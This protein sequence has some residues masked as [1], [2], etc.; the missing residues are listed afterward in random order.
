MLKPDW[1]RDRPDHIQAGILTTLL[2]DRDDVATLTA[3]DQDLRSA[4]TF[5]QEPD[6][7]DTKDAG[8]TQIERNHSRLKGTHELLHRRPVDGDADLITAFF[9]DHF[10]QTADS[11]FIFGNE[12][13]IRGHEGSKG[14]NGAPAMRAPLRESWSGR[15]APSD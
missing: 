3:C 12:Q 7:F 11:G 13:P 14:K 15:I 9:C 4:T 10:E 2:G 8:H 5:R 6:H 1:L